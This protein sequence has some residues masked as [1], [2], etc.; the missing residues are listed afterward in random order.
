M[1]V[2]KVEDEAQQ[3]E[4]VYRLLIVVLGCALILTLVVSIWFVQGKNTAEDELEKTKEPYA[5]GP[6]ALAAAQQILEEI[7]SYD[8]REIRDEFGWVDYFDEEL[9]DRYAEDVIPDIRKVI[10]ALHSVAEGTIEKSAYNIVNEDEVEVIAFI[11]QTIT[12]KADPKGVLDAQWSSLTMIRDG[13]EWLVSDI[14]PLDVP[15]P[16]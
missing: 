15:P 13:D 1:S 14:T 2:T 5:A 4:K 9:R 12:T 6:D 10:K 11:R 3:R 16:Q 8:Y 7:I